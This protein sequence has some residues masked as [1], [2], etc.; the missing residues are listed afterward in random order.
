MLCRICQ[1]EFKPNKYRPKQQV[2]SRSECQKARQIQNLRDWRLKN[3][4]YFKTLEQ[5]A[6]WRE[7]RYRYS[8]LWKSAHKEYLKEYEGAH[9]PQRKEYMR[10]Y[11]RQ[12]RRIN[13]ATLVN[14]N[15]S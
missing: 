9:N 4:D 5:D 14:R 10:D 12:R 15:K 8:R 11:M 2:C 3:P 7:S 1:K 6:S 13:P